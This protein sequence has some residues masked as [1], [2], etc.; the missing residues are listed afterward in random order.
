MIN[1]DGTDS[2]SIW[3]KNKWF[4]NP[5][6]FYRIYTIWEA[7]ET[8]IEE[9]SDLGD[10]FTRIAD[11]LVASMLDQNMLKKDFV[12]FPEITPPN[13]D[14]TLSYILSAE[15]INLRNPVVNVKEALEEP[16]TE[17]F[18]DFTDVS[19]IADESTRNLDIE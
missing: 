6:T 8:C 5:R 12:S 19:D 15:E 2:I 16:K 4:E 14:R 9:G 11:E 3:T 1:K 13:D 17:G 7:Y 18:D 10:W